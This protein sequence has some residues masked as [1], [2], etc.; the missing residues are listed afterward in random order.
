MIASESYHESPILRFLGQIAEPSPGGG[1]INIKFRRV[2][3]A[4]PQDVVVNVDNNRGGSGWMRLQI[5]VGRALPCLSAYLALV[6]QDPWSVAE[7]R[8]RGPEYV[9]STTQ[10]LAHE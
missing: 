7:G 6:L 4:P 1:R 5:T 2:E 10:H 3:C 9:L 8:N